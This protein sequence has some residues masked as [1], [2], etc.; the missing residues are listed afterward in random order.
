MTSSPHAH[1]YSLGTQRSVTEQS[2]CSQINSVQ[3]SNHTGYAGG[4]TGDK[5]TG[6]Q[7]ATLVYCLSHIVALA[8]STP[9]LH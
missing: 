6:E 3:F 5:L 8:A 9:V 2:V 7:L 1:A 4:F